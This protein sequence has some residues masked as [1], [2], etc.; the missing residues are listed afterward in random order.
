MLRIF[1]RGLRLRAR[2][3]LA[4]ALGGLLLSTMLA[5][6]TY[7]VTRNTSLRQR[8][9]SA[10]AQ[11]IDNAKVL[12]GSS[13]GEDPAYFDILTSL[14]QVAGGQPIAN[15]PTPDDRW[16][17]PSLADTDLP[18]ALIEAVRTSDGAFQMRFAN[19]EIGSTRLNSSHTDISRMP[20]SA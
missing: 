1:G 14:P 2:V 3:S 7:G 15:I 6:T 19:E 12:G 11:F 13:L 5:A 16:V 9:E 18:P 4:F 20:S 10:E 8:A 17:A